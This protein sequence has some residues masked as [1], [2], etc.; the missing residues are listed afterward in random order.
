[1]NE[2]KISAVI[3]TF[4][5]EKNVARCIESLL[6]VA[7]EIVVLDSFS[8]DGTEDLCKQYGVRF[9]TGAFEGYGTQKNRAVSLASHDYILSLDADEA[10]SDEL[11]A[12]ILAVKKA[13]SSDAFLLNRKTNFC[14]SWIQYC[15]WYP[16]QKIRLWKKEKGTWAPERLHETVR[17][18]K[19]ATVGRLKGDLLHYSFH[20]LSAQLDKLNKLSTIASE[21]AYKE[22]K[23]VYP[24]IHIVLYPFVTFLRIYF[25]RLGFL[26]GLAG[27]MVAVSIGFSKFMKYSKLYLLKKAKETPIS[28]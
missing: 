19:D 13:P 20:S 18:Q 25:L 16:D 6:P 1:M 7:D 22:N 12:S 21:E 24:L 11:K 15:G 23:K 3:I 9:Y 28:N 26:D 4:N 10:L 14:G 5:E 2:I 27:F 17:V 8:T